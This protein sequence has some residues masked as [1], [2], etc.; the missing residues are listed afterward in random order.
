MADSAD[1]PNREIRQPPLPVAAA[2]RR[3][4]VEDDDMPADEADRQAH[5]AVHMERLEAYLK[6]AGTE[7]DAQLMLE[8]ELA[9]MKCVGCLEV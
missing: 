5:V 9:L 6:K 7:P 2:D 4:P 1:Q 8:V 3:R